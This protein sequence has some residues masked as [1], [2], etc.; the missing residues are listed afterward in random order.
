[1]KKTNYRWVVRIVLISVAASVAFTFAS[2]ELLDRTGVVVAF[3]ILVLFIGIG[4]IFDIIGAAVMTAQEAPF[5]S[6]ASHRERG[7]LEALRLL[8]NAEKT[9]SFCND[10]VG[11]VTGIVSGATAALVASRLINTLGAESIFLQLLISAAV[12]GLTI[13]GK[14]V[15]KTIALNNNT[16]IVLRVGKIVNIFRIRK[17]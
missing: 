2:T 4:I 9:A 10:V 13:G 12:V 16:A 1:M 14:A 17:R 15:G 7:A 6:M 11:D 8:K 3:T 5:H